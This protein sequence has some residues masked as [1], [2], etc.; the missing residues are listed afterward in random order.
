MIA[1]QDG[2]LLFLPSLHSYCYEVY[3]RVVRFSVLV[4][5]LFFAVALTA[6]DTSRV[7]ILLSPLEL[8]SPVV[9]LVGEWK[10]A[11]THGI[12]PDV[13]VGSIDQVFVF[14][15]GAQ[16]AWYM[17]GDFEHGVQLGASLR[18]LQSNDESNG[19]S[20]V[21][22]GVAIGPII[23]YKYVAPFRLTV[24]LNGGIM[25]MSINANAS[26]TFGGKATASGSGAVPTAALWF[27]WTI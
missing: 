9:R 22:R 1:A 6:Q 2:R 12:G 19:I 24:G 20:S 4:A 27:G 17:I 23:G 21:G 10:V 13:A 7:S 15:I 25:L 3:M 18:Y 14:S 8:A 16:Y 11:R 26:D 5:S